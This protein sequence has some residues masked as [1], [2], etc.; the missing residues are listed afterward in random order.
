MDD[1]VSFPEVLDL[2]PFLAPNRSDYKVVP[3]PLGPRAPYMDWS[4]PEQGPEL[5]PVLYRLYGMSFHLCTDTAEIF[6]RRGPPR[7]D[8]RRS[9]RRILSRGS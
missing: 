8:G 5:Q 9:L 3:T 6:S 2:A 7:Y 1:F 4:T